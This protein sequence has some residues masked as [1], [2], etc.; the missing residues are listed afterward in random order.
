MGKK[1]GGA[2]GDREANG[3][4][5]ELSGNRRAVVQGC[6]GIL[7]YG[8]ELTSFRSGRLTLRLEGRGLRLLRLTESSAV[9]EG[10]IRRVVYDLGEQGEE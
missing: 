5:V 4:F 8:E 2:V 6:D 10:T 9:V 3:L 1:G 7:D